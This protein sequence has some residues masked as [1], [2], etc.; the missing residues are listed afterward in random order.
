MSQSSPIKHAND[1][2]KGMPSYKYTKMHPRLATSLSR[3]SV[4]ITN[5]LHRVF[6]N[7]YLDTNDDTF[8]K[9]Y[10]SVA[11]TA[12]L[13]HA[14]FL[15][16]HGAVSEEVDHVPIFSG[17][18]DEDLWDSNECMGSSSDND[19]GMEDCT[20]LLKLGPEEEDKVNQNIG[21]D[22]SEEHVTASEIVA[23][24]EKEEDAGSAPEISAPIIPLIDENSVAVPDTS[25]PE[26]VSVP[27]IPQEQKVEEKKE[28]RQS[29]IPENTL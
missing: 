28:S 11:A 26:P 25:D 12:K 20:L 8:V 14:A 9:A 3:C 4:Y 2:P 15:K 27:V 29:G 5:E 24:A 21:V 6:L 18:P 1:S 22:V 10:K 7:A 16:I 13:S 19:D 17:I 23:A